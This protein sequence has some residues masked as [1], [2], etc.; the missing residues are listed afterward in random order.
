MA[1]GVAC[2]LGVHAVV[3][4]VSAM[5]PLGREPMSPPRLAVDPGER[6]VRVM[7]V[8]SR[9]A[10]EATA[11]PERPRAPTRRARRP[12]E[13]VQPPPPSTIDAEFAPSALRPDG[14]VVL[15][16][17]PALSALHPDAASTN[18]ERVARA[19]NERAP[20]LAPPPLP[21]EVCL[22]EPS[23]DATSALASAGA[24]PEDA[25]AES[26][27]RLTGEIAPVYPALPPSRR[28]GSG[29]SECPRPG[30]RLCRRRA[31]RESPRP[32]APG[33]RGNRRRAGGPI[34]SRES[35][36]QPGGVLDS[37]PGPVRAGVS[38]RDLGAGGRSS[39]RS[40][41]SL[42]NPADS[43]SAPHEPGVE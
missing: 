19:S 20:D 8:A 36:R 15:C 29:R 2:S 5:L 43:H 35:R 37:C 27:A 26:P 11:S 39:P 28:G 1:A 38:A 25:G 30:E 31:R 12:E 32:C 10:T 17:D 7:L 18:V 24:P 42:G 13:V 14:P 22:P 6:S 9:R 40:G 34:C 41:T 21:P 4:V 16:E 3:L 23:R 33:R